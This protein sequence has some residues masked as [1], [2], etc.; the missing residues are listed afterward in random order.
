[1]GPKS[2]LNPP[3]AGRRPGVRGAEAA[4]SPVEDR[5]AQGVPS[6]P[7]TLGDESA[8]GI[9][10]LLSPTEL[11]HL[12]GVSR[13][14]VYT[15]VEEH[16][17]PAYKFGRKLAFE[18]PAVRRW[19]ETHRIGAWPESCVEPVDGAGI[20]SMPEGLQGE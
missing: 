4:P 14:W 7:C 5:A 9:G 15:Q 8:V 20:H 18:V 19:L 2:V 11:A 13:R 6:S 17:M 3:G 12:L 16:G 1:M 10:R